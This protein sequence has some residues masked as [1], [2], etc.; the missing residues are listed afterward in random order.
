MS[1]E[2]AYILD[3]RGLG[4]HPGSKPAETASPRKWIGVHFECCGVYTRLY[5][6]QQGTAYEGYCPHCTRPVRVAIGP[7]GTAHRMFRAS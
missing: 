1:E 2:P 6:N 4:E 7:Q 5:R 3:I